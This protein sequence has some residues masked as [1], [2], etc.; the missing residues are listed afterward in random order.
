MAPPAKKNEQ[1]K[2]A[3]APSS[4]SSNER[5][6]PGGTKRPAS[7]MD[8]E[9]DEDELSVGQY[10][11]PPG[12]MNL[13][14]S[15]DVEAVFKNGRLVDIV[16]KDNPANL[17][18]GT[19]VGSTFAVKT[20]SEQAKDTADQY[21]KTFNNGVWPH[22]LNTYTRLNPMARNQVRRPIGSQQAAPRALLAP[23]TGS[24]ASASASVAASTAG[25]STRANSEEP[26]GPAAGAQK[27]RRGRKKQKTEDGPVVCGRCGSDT[28][29]LQQCAAQPDEDGM[30]RGCAKHN[31]TKHN[32][33]DCSL[34]PRTLE[35]KKAYFVDFRAGLPPLDGDDRWEEIVE[36][37]AD[38]NKRWKTEDLPLTADFAQSV[39]PDT[40]ANFDY[41]SK[42]RGQLGEDPSSN[43]WD[44]F[45]YYW[46]G[47]APEADDGA[48]SSVTHDTMNVDKDDDKDDF[49]PTE[50]TSDQVH[51]T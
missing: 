13:V 23:N 40:Y 4:G 45:E 46:W 16:D 25:Q 1:K 7:S 32:M 10:R 48:E 28:H 39:S 41:S 20:T 2:R 51:L 30:I 42:A 8:L 29:T 6:P 3:G 31:T 50:M 19:M 44:N 43:C 47:P 35:E 24:F 27:S 26:A 15:R 21:W 5:P 17:E 38:E 14:P 37:Y 9:E 18:L 49:G 11:A 34:K 33:R 22:T 36:W 12:R